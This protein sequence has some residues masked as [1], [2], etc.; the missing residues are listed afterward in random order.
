[1]IDSFDV[2]SRASGLSVMDF[3]S[4]SFSSMMYLYGYA[5]VHWSVACCGGDGCATI[6]ECAL[7]KGAL[8]LS[9]FALALA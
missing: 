8:Y 7:L 4:G 1:M 3:M 6:E 2:C 9:A 5:C